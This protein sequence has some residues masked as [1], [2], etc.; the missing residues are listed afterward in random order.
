MTFTLVK[1][2]IS[3]SE[4]RRFVM[5]KACFYNTKERQPHIVVNIPYPQ[6]VF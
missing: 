1:A 6:Q 3:G 2:V 4:R 5:Q